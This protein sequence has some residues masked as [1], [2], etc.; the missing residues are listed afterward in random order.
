MKESQRLR[1]SRLHIHNESPPALQRSMLAVPAVHPQ[2]GHCRHTLRMPHWAAAPCTVLCCNSACKGW[3][4]GPRL[5]ARGTGTLVCGLILSASRRRGTTTT[6]GV[7]LPFT[8]K[9][10]PQPSQSHTHRASRGC[11]RPLA[12]LE[13]ATRPSLVRNRDPPPESHLE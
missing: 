13:L 12:E 7:R 4:L 1:H 10:S 3:P 6:C 8:L 5:V 2:Q 9:T 11:A